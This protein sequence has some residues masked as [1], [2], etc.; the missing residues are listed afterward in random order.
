MFAHLDDPDPLTPGPRERTALAARLHRRHRRSRLT[1]TASLIAVAA[2]A[3]T[4]LLVTSSQPSSTSVGVTTGPGVKPRSS[5]RQGAVSITTKSFGGAFVPDEVVT[6]DGAGWL[7]DTR[8]T[9]GGTPVAGCRVARLDL[10]TLSV[11]SY[12]LPVCG[13]VA[14]AGDGALYMQTAA[15]SKGQTYAIRIERF[16]TTTHRAQLLPAVSATIPVGSGIAHTQLAYVDGSLWLYYLTG[17]ESVVVQLS[18]ATGAVLR[19]YHSVPSIGGTH[20]IIVGVRADVWFA[21]GAGSGASFLRVNSRTGAAR[22]FHL[23]RDYGS[24]YAMDAIPGQLY[25]AYLVPGQ[26]ATHLARLSSDGILVGNS[27]PEPVGSW[28]V[29]AGGEIFGVGPSSGCSVDNLA[30]RRVDMTTL[31]ST[32]LTSV[33]LPAPAC[34][35]ETGPDLTASS[36]DS[37]LVLY[38]TE[39]TATVYRFAVPNA[40]SPSTERPT[41]ASTASTRTPSPLKGRS[42][43]T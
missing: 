24:V 35:G 32:P 27:G 10:A 38:T 30:L 20:P 8:L 33:R 21:G 5:T 43:T 37:I 42:A 23:D 22:A 6:A 25:F 2:I 4:T 29:A 12:P 41:T 36:G 19:T 17:A 28:L 31:R 39:P 11:L 26:P 3:G 34:A 13:T 18:P 7:L 14:T 9:G 16:S 1:F 15:V 40:V